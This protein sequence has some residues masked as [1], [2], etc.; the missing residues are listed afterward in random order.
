[1]DVAAGDGIADTEHAEAPARIAKLNRVF[2]AKQ[3]LVIDGAQIA[4]KRLERCAASRTGEAERTGSQSPLF[5]PVRR[6][7][8][9]S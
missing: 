2:A 8:W 4:G 3:R 6:P 1:M 9:V 7:R 5:Q